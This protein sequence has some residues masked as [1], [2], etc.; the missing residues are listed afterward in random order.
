MIIFLS[1]SLNKCSGYSKEPS[2]FK[3]TILLCAQQNI[4]FGW[5]IRK[6]FFNYPPLSHALILQKMHF[7]IKNTLLFSQNKNLRAGF[8]G[9]LMLN[10]H[11]QVGMCLLYAS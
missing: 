8:M 7:N 6:L 2:Q 1:I 3:E 9:N 4:C 11:A 10:A 5:E